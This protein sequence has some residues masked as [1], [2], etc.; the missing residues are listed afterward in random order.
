MS[1]SRI[2]K[3]IKESCKEDKIMQGLLMDLLDYNLSG[4][5]WYKEE[6][7]KKIEKYVK[8]TEGYHED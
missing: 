8:E 3:A 5:Q 7:I 1:T 4:R 2:A 6:Y